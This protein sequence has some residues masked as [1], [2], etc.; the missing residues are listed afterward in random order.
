MHF[1]LYTSF[2]PSSQLTLPHPS[3]PPIPPHSGV[4]VKSWLH[5]H[6]VVVCKEPTGWITTHVLPLSSAAVALCVPPGQ[7]LHPESAAVGPG[8][9]PDGPAGHPSSL[10]AHPG[11]WFLHKE[12]ASIH[13]P[14]PEAACV[15]KL[16]PLQQ[17]SHQR[18][19]G[20]RLWRREAAHAAGEKT[21]PSGGTAEHLE[22]VDLRGQCNCSPRAVSI[23]IRV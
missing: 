4:P 15:S 16:L 21:Q 23:L 17:P 22:R 1:P 19:R 8:R 12:P 2:D 5:S 9:P 20:W 18:C 3:P 13:L 6:V 14:E 10:G 7:G 11:S